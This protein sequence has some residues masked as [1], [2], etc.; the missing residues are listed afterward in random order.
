MLVL[1]FSL[2]NISLGP[3]ISLH[4]LGSSFL[5]TN[6]LKIPKFDVEVWNQFKRLNMTMKR[7]YKRVKQ[8]SL[9]E[10][11]VIKNKE[12]RVSLIKLSP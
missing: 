4:C 1:H 8:W 3:K 2:C 9:L 12:Y 6:V 11:R 10:V 7:E 5:N